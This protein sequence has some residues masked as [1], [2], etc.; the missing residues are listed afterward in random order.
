MQDLTP[1]DPESMHQAWLQAVRKAELARNRAAR[2]A[3][4]IEEEA[5][6]ELRH[7]AWAQLG[8]FERWRTKPEDVWVDERLVK[9]VASTWTGDDSTWRLAVSDNQWYLSQAAAYRAHR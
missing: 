8:W 7:R 9:A 6:A 2:R 3:K 1:L 4:Q 5:R